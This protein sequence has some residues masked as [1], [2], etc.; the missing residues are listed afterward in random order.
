MSNWQSI[1]P[2]TPYRP[3]LQA[4]GCNVYLNGCNL[5]VELEANV[6]Q[7]GGASDFGKAWLTYTNLTSA[8]NAGTFGYISI[9]D[10]AGWG[11]AG[12]EVATK[13]T[14]EDIKDYLSI[15][16]TRFSN[17]PLI[18]TSNLQV[19]TISAKNTSNSNVYFNSSLTMASGKSINLNN[20]VILN[21]AT[22]YTNY[23]TTD[24]ITGK[25]GS[26][27]NFS[28]LLDMNGSSIYNANIL[29]LVG[30]GAA[31]ATLQFFD[32]DYATI[33]ELKA[34]GAN[35]VLDVTPNTFSVTS[36]MTNFNCDLDITQHN[37]S[38]VN[39]VR[40]NLSYYGIPDTSDFVN[41]RYYS[42]Y[43]TYSYDEMEYIP[44]ASDWCK[45]S[46]SQDVDMGGNSITNASK[47]FTGD[48]QQPCIQ[49]GTV[50]IDVGGYS[51][52]TLPNSYPS[53]YIV[54]VTAMSS[55]TSCW[56]EVLSTASFRV[57]G[58]A[59]QDYAWS[60]MGLL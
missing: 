46:A 5:S 7:L 22:V 53:T 11:I 29:R 20:N 43:M 35:L 51:D 17:V 25:S 50:N 14:P 15:S 59:G 13:E 19:N 18:D 36:A 37:L 9:Y 48:T 33:G 27:I 24:N 49:F 10:V 23:L 8:I 42:G 21:G 3:T 41:V 38:N 52:I 28:G 60:T 26:T 54:Q 45:F 32:T 40:M 2:F 31:Q 44:I 4:A 57:H 58:T 6:S 30:T 16:S 56:A 47:I 12:R 39:F 1:N 55:S 34:D